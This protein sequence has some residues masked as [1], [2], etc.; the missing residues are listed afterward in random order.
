MLRH[1]VNVLEIANA[2]PGASHHR[3]AVFEQVKLR[4]AAALLD[5]LFQV[6]TRQ[7]GEIVDQAHHILG[8]F[9]HKLACVD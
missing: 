5:Q 1:V 4:R 2:V 6:L 3:Q 7:V 8:E 9:D